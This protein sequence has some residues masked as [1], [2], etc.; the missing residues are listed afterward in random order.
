MSSCYPCRGG[1]T[2]ERRIL[3]SR[4]TDY[5]I[6]QNRLYRCRHLGHRRLDPALP[7]RRRDGTSVQRADRLSA[8]LLRLPGGR[9]CVADHIFP[10]WIESGATPCTHVPEH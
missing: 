10:D 1:Y 5:E 2:D 7:A 3:T 6:C 4:E 8:I 9:A